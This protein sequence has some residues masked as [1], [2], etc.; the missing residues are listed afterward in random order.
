MPLD[1]AHRSASGNHGFQVGGMG[2]LEPLICTAAIHR[3]LWGNWDE[4]GFCDST[5]L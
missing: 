5:N 4:I 3:L 2:R 1:E